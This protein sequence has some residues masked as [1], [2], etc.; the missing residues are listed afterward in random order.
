MPTLKSRPVRIAFANIYKISAQPMKASSINSKPSVPATC[1]ASAKAKLMLGK[2][3]VSAYQLGRESRL[4]LL[5]NQDSPARLSRM[6]AYYD[7]F[8]RAQA[9]QIRELRVALVTL[10]TMQAEIDHKLTELSVRWN[11]Q[12]KQ[13][14]NSLQDQRDQRQLV[15]AGLA[16]QINSDEVLLKRTEQQPQGSGIITGQAV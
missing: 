12:Q 1:K 8:S 16:G 7:Y 13:A 9:G 11:L 3:I 5:L 15:I 14:L 2:Q 6:L 10:D 4:K